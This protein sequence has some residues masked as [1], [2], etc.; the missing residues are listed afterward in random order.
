[1]ELA[2]EEH[3][4]ISFSKQFH[5]NMHS[6]IVFKYETMLLEAHTYPCQSKMSSRIQHLSMAYNIQKNNFIYINIKIIK[7]RERERERERDQKV[8]SSL[9]YMI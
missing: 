5:T 8:L 7:R 9:K 4:I 3:M 2:N 1:V 6:N